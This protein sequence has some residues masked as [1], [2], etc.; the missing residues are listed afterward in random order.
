MKLSDLLAEGKLLWAYCCE[1]GHERDLDPSGLPLP[2][3]IAV[4]H[5]RHRMRCSRCGSRKIDTRP[6]LYPGGVVAMREKSK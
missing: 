5:V 4:C 6:E 2:G 3:D 1:C